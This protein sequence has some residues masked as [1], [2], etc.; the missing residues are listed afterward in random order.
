MLPFEGASACED[1]AI[2]LRA[3]LFIGDGVCMSEMGDSGVDALE[4]IALKGVETTGSSSSSRGR[5]GE[6]GAI[7]SSMVDV[8][9][10]GNVFE[11]VKAR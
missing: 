11:K 7:G 5:L 4:L 10:I 8:E 2:V 1:V 3:V 6:T 9:I